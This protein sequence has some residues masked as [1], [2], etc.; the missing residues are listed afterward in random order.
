MTKTAEAIDDLLKEGKE[1]RRKTRL[2]PRRKV[3]KIPD[4][5]VLC[6]ITTICRSCK[7][8]YKHPSPNL[9]IRF[10]RHYVRTREWSSALSGVQRETMEIEEDSASCRECFPNGLLEM[11]EVDKVPN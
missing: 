6:E 9:L 10:G 2:P 1:E 5:L 7:R 8:E 11:G 4:A 3:E